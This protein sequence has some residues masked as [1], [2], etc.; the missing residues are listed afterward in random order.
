PKSYADRLKQ[1]NDE[2]DEF[3]DEQE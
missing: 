1:V 3:E 2:S